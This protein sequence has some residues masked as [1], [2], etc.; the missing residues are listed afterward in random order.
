MSVT[1]LNGSSSVIREVEKNV[2]N[3]VLY[4]NASED[5]AGDAEEIQ[6]STDF[7]CSVSASTDEE[8]ITILTTCVD[9]SL[10]V[11]IYGPIGETPFAI[12]FAY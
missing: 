1:Y 4:V 5:Y 11:S 12:T 2:E 7:P 10:R 8:V 3:G 6:V 9:N